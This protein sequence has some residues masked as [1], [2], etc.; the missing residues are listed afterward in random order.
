MNDIPFSAGP[1]DFTQP[2]HCNYGQYRDVLALAERKGFKPARTLCLTGG[3]VITFKAILPSA[4]TNAQDATVDASACP[5]TI[6]GA[7]NQS[8]S[9]RNLDGEASSIEEGL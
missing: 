4:T 2:V 1:I 8:S 7:S 5:Y 3:F 9:Y 6:D